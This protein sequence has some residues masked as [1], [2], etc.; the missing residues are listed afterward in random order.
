M[1]NPGFE[2][3]DTCPNL[4]ELHGLKHWIQPTIGSAD[5]YNECSPKYFKLPETY[6]GYQPAHEGKGCVAIYCSG[7]YSV[8]RNYREY[9]Q[10]RLIEPLKKGQKY[11]VVFYVCLADLCKWSVD[12]IGAYFSEDPIRSAQRYSF[13]YFKPATSIASGQFPDSRKCYPQVYY[14]DGY[15]NDKEKWTLVSGEFIAQGGEQYI[16]IGNF[17]DSDERPPSKVVTGKRTGA[18]YF[19]DDVGVEPVFD[20]VIL[21]AKKDTVKPYEEGQTF[22]LNNIYF[23][24]DRSELLPASF[25]SLDSLVDIMSSNPGMK[26][27]IRGHTD[28]VASEKHNLDLSSAR[29]KA[30]RDYLIV[31]GIGDE[32]LTS[33]GYGEALPIATNETKEGRQLN[34]RVEFRI[35]K[36]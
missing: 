30:V 22:V 4:Q 9:V 14:Q 20:T 18:Y 1:P 11:K 31:K 33:N 15:L 24:T 32:R 19:I 2:D 28:N 17:F 3:H 23:D 26:I 6:W 21:P 36:I 12:C 35:M 27:E 7:W 13:G 10:A 34:R 8:D 16:T 5:Y 29:A 25:K